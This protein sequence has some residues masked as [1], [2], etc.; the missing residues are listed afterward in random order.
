MRDGSDRRPEGHRTHVATGAPP[1]HGASRGGSP[2]HSPTGQHSALGRELEKYTSAETPVQLRGTS[3]GEGACRGPRKPSW[4]AK[5]DIT[6]RDALGKIAAL[7]ELRARS[8]EAR[9]VGLDLAVQGAMGPRKASDRAHLVAGQSTSA[10]WGSASG[11]GIQ[12]TALANGT[13]GKGPARQRKGDERG[14]TVRGVQ[15]TVPPTACE[16]NAETPPVGA[17]LRSERRPSAAY[18]EPSRIL[19]R[20]LARDQR[21]SVRPKAQ[22]PGPSRNGSM[23]LEG[24]TE[25][26]K[27][28]QGR[29]AHGGL[30]GRNVLEPDS[31]ATLVGSSQAQPAH[32][33]HRTR[34]P[35]MPQ[36]NLERRSHRSPATDP[37]RPS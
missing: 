28:D 26:S 11:R 23:K 22:R 33:A 13:T 10:R 3:P 17:V 2:T 24:R 29:Q 5:R 15:R 21:N 34:S 4:V 27:P 19:R 36:A 18:S 6:R 30:P 32:P 20:S 31:S 35:G 1:R 8:R 12:P 14:K 9:Q 16:P 7:G 37:A 25:K